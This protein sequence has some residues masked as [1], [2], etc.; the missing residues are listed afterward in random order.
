MSYYSNIVKAEKEIETVYAEAETPMATVCLNLSSLMDSISKNSDKKNQLTK[1][2]ERRVAYLKDTKGTDKATILRQDKIKK[3]Y[4]DKI[5]K[6]E[7]EKKLYSDY[8][9]N[10]SIDVE[11]D[12]DSI[13]QYVSKKEKE[14][15][16]LN[17]SYD[18]KINMLNAKREAEIEA[19][20][21]AITAK[22][23]KK[24]KAIYNHKEKMHNNKLKINQLEQSILQCQKDCDDELLK[25]LDESAPVVEPMTLHTKRNMLIQL[26]EEA[27]KL[28]SQYDNTVRERQRYQDR[29]D[30]KILSISNKYGVAPPGKWNDNAY[31]GSNPTSLASVSTIEK[32]V[33]EYAE[34]PVKKAKKT[35]VIVEPVII[36][37]VNSVVSED[38][39][40][41]EEEEQED[42]EEEE[43]ED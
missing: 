31:G 19:I 18:I 13:T 29:T 35:V 24:E 1:D 42:E 5:A 22:V 26:E 23:D 43:D 39:E 2:I 4:R 11:S 9:A 41:E 21:S 33:L 37:S 27:V 36:P 17:A 32:P 34:K 30:A 10:R 38:E 3:F 25:M 6:I 15:E 12:G 20:K 8:I 7:N 28:W 16:M 40:Q 14:I